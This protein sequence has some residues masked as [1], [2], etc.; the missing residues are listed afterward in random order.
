MAESGGIG[1]PGANAG[2]NPDRIDRFLRA[3]TANPGQNPP[4]DGIAS[5][6]PAP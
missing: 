4:I 1:G 3:L 5:L 6:G 2:E